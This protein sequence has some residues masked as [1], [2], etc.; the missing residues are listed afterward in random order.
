MLV[1]ESRRGSFFRGGNISLSTFLMMSQMFVGVKTTYTVERL[2]SAT[3]RANL[4]SSTN[5]RVAPL[6]VALRPSP[7]IAGSVMLVSTAI[8]PMTTSNSSNVNAPWPSAPCL[9]RLVPEFFM[10][11]AKRTL[12][13]ASSGYCPCWHPGS[14]SHSCRHL[15]RGRGTR[16]SPACWLDIPY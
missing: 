8:I 1:S 14:H 10:P 7:F 9:R 13:T 12:F 6:L 5:W 4:K 16:P 15:H 2:R 3:C 11:L